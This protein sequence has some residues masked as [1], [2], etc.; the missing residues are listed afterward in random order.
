MWVEERHARDLRKNLYGFCPTCL[1]GWQSVCHKGLLRNNFKWSYKSLKCNRVC[2]VGQW[3]PLR[4]TINSVSRQ[5]H[6]WMREFFEILNVIFKQFHINLTTTWACWTPRRMKEENQ[7]PNFQVQATF[8]APAV[9]STASVINPNFVN[10]FSHWA[11]AWNINNYWINL[12]KSRL[13][14]Q[15]KHGLP[16][17]DLEPP[18]TLQL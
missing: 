7:P 15:E 9:S 1:G 10:V 4:W 3:A 18:S 12:Y 11:R 14:S 17:D 13:G 5:S 8:A 6:W 16:E 2:W